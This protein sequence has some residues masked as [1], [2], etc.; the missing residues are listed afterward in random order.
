MRKS[1]AH[2]NAK[3]V[4]EGGKGVKDD[5]QFCFLILWKWRK[6][7]FL[8]FPK[9]MRLRYFSSNEG[10]FSRHAERRLG[11]GSNGRIGAAGHCPA[12]AGHSSQILQARNWA[13]EETQGGQCAASVISFLAII[14]LQSLPSP[15]STY[16]FLGSQKI[17]LA[18]FF[19]KM[20]RLKI[21]NLNFQ[22]TPNRKWCVGWY[23]GSRAKCEFVFLRMKYYC[24]KYKYFL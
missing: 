14:A 6:F 20:Y 18:H 4:K 12:A 23:A 13:A 21:L 22:W 9:K 17:Q 1:L 8:E 15:I 10:D 11:C 24:F 19:S 5:R 16:Y 3:K 7:F 2:L